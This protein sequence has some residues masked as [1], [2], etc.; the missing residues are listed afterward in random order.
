MITLVYSE[1]SDEAWE[2][3]VT[4]FDNGNDGA[5]LVSPAGNTTG[6]VT[7]SGNVKFSEM[8]YVFNAQSADA[9]VVAVPFEGNGALTRGTAA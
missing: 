3:I 7:F 2:E 9:I 1:T 8:P 4:L 5:I 6:D